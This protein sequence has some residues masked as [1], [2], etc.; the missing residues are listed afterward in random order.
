[1]KSKF[2]AELQ[3]SVDEGEAPVKPVQIWISHLE[4]WWCFYPKELKSSTE[5]IPFKLEWFQTPSSPFHDSLQT[6]PRCGAL[7]GRVGV[8]GNS[9]WHFW[10]PSE[11]P[12]G[13]F[14][15]PR[16]GFK[17]T[18]GLKQ[19]HI[20]GIWGR[21]GSL[22]LL[23]PGNPCWGFL[24]L[25]FQSANTTVPLVLA[26][27]S[28]LSAFEL[29]MDYLQ[30]EFVLMFPSSGNREKI[31]EQMLCPGWNPH[32][33]RSS[34]LSE[35]PHLTSHLSLRFQDGQPG[36]NSQNSSWGHSNSLARLAGLLLCWASW[37]SCV[38]RNGFASKQSRTFGE[39]EV[40]DEVLSNPSLFSCVFLVVPVTGIPDFFGESPQD[41]LCVE[42]IMGFH[43]Q[44]PPWQ[45][46]CSFLP[47]GDPSAD[48]DG[49][50]EWLHPWVGW[51]GPRGFS[52]CSDM[53]WVGWILGLIPGKPLLNP[54]PSIPSASSTWTTSWAFNPFIVSWAEI[55]FPPT[56]VQSQLRGAECSKVLTAAW[57]RVLPSIH[58]LQ[59]GKPREF[60]CSN[61]S[62]LCF[63]HCQACRA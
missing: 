60:G 8:T 34:W 51:G 48:P 30:C 14:E 23:R 15:L 62:P 25:C 16:D 46:S 5:I 33:N 4:W 50:A 56:S 39:Q 27:K 7:A 53:D 24:S 49:I 31:D 59:P 1:M 45:C 22:T 44:P 18:L 61:P 21:N 6:S 41:C 3:I 20:L 28:C 36:R 43:L 40:A 2:L 26:L 17:A 9:W 35:F 37:G 52:G 47:W 57:P 54:N 32:H 58:C 55:N 38:Y 10:E 12:P 19:L 13:W 42:Q 29:D 63:L 11:L